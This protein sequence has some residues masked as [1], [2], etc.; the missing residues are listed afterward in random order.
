MP[1]DKANAS[2]RMH[3]MVVEVACQCDSGPDGL[4]L[5]TQC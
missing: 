1:D 3:Q 4:T 2:I 5:K